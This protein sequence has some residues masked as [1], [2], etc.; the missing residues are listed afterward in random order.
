MVAVPRRDCACPLA[1]DLAPVADS[2]HQ[3]Q[4]LGVLDGANDPVVAHPALPELAQFRALQGLADAAGV[5]QGS[6]ALVQQF[7]Q[8]ADHPRLLPL[9]PFVHDR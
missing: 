1:V 4:Q 7:Q 9:Q 3:D 8:P 2:H 6:D 5:L